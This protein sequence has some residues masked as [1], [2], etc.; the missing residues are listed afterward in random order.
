[1]HKLWKQITPSDFSWEREALAL[2][3]ICPVQRECLDYAYDAREHFG[4]WGG[5]NE[6]QRRTK[7]RR[8]A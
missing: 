7:F 6:K 5:V 8:S 4:I 3:R 1:M 2:C